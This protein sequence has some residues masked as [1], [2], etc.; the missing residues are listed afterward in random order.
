M[1]LRT[2]STEMCTEEK[3]DKCEGPW[4]IKSFENSG[5]NIHWIKGKTTISF[6]KF[7]VI[8]ILSTNEYNRY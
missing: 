3:I 1:W 6:G 4:K 8:Y 2:D 5:A 7:W